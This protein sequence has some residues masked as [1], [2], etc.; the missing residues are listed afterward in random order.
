MRH[1][2]RAVMAE[3]YKLYAKKNIFNSKY[4]V[5]NLQIGLL[6]FVL[7]VMF[8]GSVILITTD[9]KSDEVAATD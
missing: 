9:S 7:V 4:L 8:V 6:L 5:R 3:R 2:R 1:S